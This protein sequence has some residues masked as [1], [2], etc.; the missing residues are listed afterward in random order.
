MP[1]TKTRRP[2]GRS[3]SAQRPNAPTVS[4]AAERPSGATLA[5]NRPST[6]SGRHSGARPRN[7]RLPAEPAAQR[8]Q[9]VPSERAA[10]DG[11]APDQGSGT[12]SRPPRRRPPTPPGARR[13]RAA[14]GSGQRSRP[15]RGT[16]RS[17]NEDRT[18][19]RLAAPLTPDPARCDPPA[20]AARVDSA[21][22]VAA[23]PSLAAP[24]PADM[25]GSV[26]DRISS[27]LRPT[28][29][30]GA[31]APSPPTAPPWP[32]TAPPGPDSADGSAGSVPCAPSL[33]DHRPPARTPRSPIPIRRR[34]G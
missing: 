8:R 25:G 32:T 6:T 33:A 24:T 20:T 13:G 31:P 19:I 34:P 5:S 17:S 23:E 11:S 21:P 27:S 14:P 9:D 12:R 16:T 4:N 28:V 2:I 26:R 7:G 15:Y 3:I 18:A 22:P 10:G 1:P 29:A 30:R